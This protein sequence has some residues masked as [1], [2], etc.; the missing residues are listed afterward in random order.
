MEINREREEQFKYISLLTRLNADKSREEKYLIILSRD[1]LNGFQ[2]ITE[3][4]IEKSKEFQYFYD[5]IISFEELREKMNEFRW[6]NEFLIEN[7][8]NF[9]EYRK[10]YFAVA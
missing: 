9:K 5:F 3:N 6:S 10:L 7:G 2:A 1:L 8:I 4:G